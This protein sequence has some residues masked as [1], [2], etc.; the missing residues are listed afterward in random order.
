M[1]IVLLNEAAED[2]VSLHVFSALKGSESL[3]LKSIPPA[4]CYSPFASS[5]CIHTMQPFPPFDVFSHAG[6]F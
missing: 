6:G 2:L 1:M 4:G 3:D 5:T